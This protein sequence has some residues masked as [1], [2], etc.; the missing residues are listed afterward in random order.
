MADYLVIQTINSAE[1]GGGPVVRF[2]VTAKNMTE[3]VSKILPEI[4]ELHNEDEVQ[5]Y[6]VTSMKQLT[7]QIENVTSLV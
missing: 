5:I 7:V 3:V 2:P 6:R 1:Y 4:L